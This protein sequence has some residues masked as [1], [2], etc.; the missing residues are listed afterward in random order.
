MKTFR[1]HNMRRKLKKERYRAIYG[2]LSKEPVAWTRTELQAKESRARLDAALEAAKRI[3]PEETLA[4]VD[5]NPNDL[6]AANTLLRGHYY[7]RHCGLSFDDF[8][9]VGRRYFGTLDCTPGFEGAWDLL[10]MAS[11]AQGA[12]G[13]H[14]TFQF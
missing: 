14:R 13:R 2:G 12:F 11:L 7:E 8:R 3:Q 4:L 10:E 6:H 1:Y 9:K 5:V